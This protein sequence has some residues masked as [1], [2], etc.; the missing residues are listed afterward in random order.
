ML[1]PRTLARHS[2]VEKTGKETSRTMCGECCRLEL[3]PEMWETKK[4]AWRQA[5]QK[6]R[7][8]K[9]QEGLHLKQES[10]HLRKGSSWGRQWGQGL[11]QVWAWIT[12]VAVDNHGCNNPFFVFMIIDFVEASAETLF[13]NTWENEFL[14]QR[15]LF[16]AYPFPFP[17]LMTFL[18]ANLGKESHHFQKCFGTLA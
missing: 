9:V 1:W 8:Q 6:R 7:G 10:G 12:A 14:C 17:P 16:L 5:F 3:C 11:R 18:E 15:N 13:G 2:L 4:W